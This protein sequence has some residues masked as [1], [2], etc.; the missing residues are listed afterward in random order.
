VA[1]L[2]IWFGVVAV[3]GN[4]A[5]VGAN[6]AIGSNVAQ[7]SAY[8]FERNKGGA[9]NWG[10]VKKLTV[11]DG[12]KNDAFGSS[13]AIHGDTAIVGASHAETGSSN[14]QGSAYVFLPGTPR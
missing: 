13:L 11:S 9:N 3:Y 1:R 7:G 4:T 10:E 5:I 12:A 8:I 2:A 6:E 14:K